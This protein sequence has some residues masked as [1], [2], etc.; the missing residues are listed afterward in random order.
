MISFKNEIE[1]IRYKQSIKN[2]L[3]NVRIF[4]IHLYLNIKYEHLCLYIY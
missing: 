3:K 2:K 4:K 1:Y